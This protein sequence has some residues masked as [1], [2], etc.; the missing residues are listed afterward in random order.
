MSLSSK[1]IRPMPLRTRVG[2]TWE[3]IPPA[4]T[5]KTLLLEKTSWS[6]PEIF[7]WRSSAPGIALP[8]SLI[9]VLE[10]VNAGRI[11]FHSLTVDFQFKVLI[12]PH[13]PDVS[14]A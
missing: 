12:E 2:A 9:D 13:E 7:R 8:R 1:V 10:Q 14:V 4:P 5:H 11:G 3:T 6:N